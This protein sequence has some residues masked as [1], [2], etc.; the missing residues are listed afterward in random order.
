MNK[1]GLIGIQTL[2]LVCSV[3]L[4]ASGQPDPIPLQR[5]QFTDKLVESYLRH[6]WSKTDAPFIHVSASVDPADN[7]YIYTV[8]SIRYFENVE[9]FTSPYWGQWRGKIILSYGWVEPKAFCRITDTT[10]LSN[11]KQYALQVLPKAIV[12]EPGSHTLRLR[13]IW[14]EGPSFTV[15]VVKGREAYYYDSSGYDSREV[16][17]TLP[18]VPETSKK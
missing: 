7:G 12:R 17:D 2:M 5:I 16:P 14:Y 6:F 10:A 13:M 1:Y 3:L 4:S 15:K 11:L 18:P 8:V 9:P